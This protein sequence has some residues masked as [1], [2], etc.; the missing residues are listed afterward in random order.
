MLSVLPLLQL[1][2][3]SRLDLPSVRD[4]DMWCL[5]EHTMLCVHLLQLASRTVRH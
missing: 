5:R 1:L 3:S 4:G 2:P